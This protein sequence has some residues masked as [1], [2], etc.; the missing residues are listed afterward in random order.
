MCLYA[1]L[2]GSGRAAPPSTL[3]RRAWFAGRPPG[4]NVES[5]GSGRTADARAI[6]PRVHTARRLARWTTATDTGNNREDG[7]KN[8]ALNR[9]KGIGS[10]RRKW[11]HD[12]RGRRLEAA[13]PARDNPWRESLPHMLLSPSSRAH[14]PVA[15]LA[16][17]RIY[18]PS[19]KG[20]PRIRG[21][22]W[23][24]LPPGAV[25]QG[26]RSPAWRCDPG[27]TEGLASRDR[28]IGPDRVVRILD[29][30]HGARRGPR[31]FE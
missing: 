26:E 5:N 14:A 9:G 27:T 2:P 30:R 20:T 8:H 10:N 29:I 22:L 19:P 25:N 23:V 12:R 7:W 18:I 11:D 16:E 15:Q 13:E 6:N 4:P 17:Q 31:Q 3:R 1:C 28:V 24:R 21:R